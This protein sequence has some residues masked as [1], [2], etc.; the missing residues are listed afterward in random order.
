MANRTPEI[1]EIPPEFAHDLHNLEYLETADIVLFMA[2]NQFMVMDE[3]LAAFRQAYPE[4]SRIFYE[5]L[6]PGLELKQI[7]AGGARLG[8]RE[9]RGTPDVYTA[10]SEAAME[11]LRRRGYIEDYFVYLHNRLVLMVPEGN[12]AGI[13][14]V[15]DLG[16]EEVRISQPGPL[17]DITRYIVA[18]Y[19][20]AGGE[21]LVKK[22]MEEKKAA[23]TTLPT[24]VHHRETPRRIKEGTA[25][26]GPVWATEVENARREGLKVEAV[27]PGKKL[28]QRE[29]VNYF[30]AAL[31][32][33]PHPENAA[34]FLEFIRSRQAQEIYAGYGFVPHFY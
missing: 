3:L 14:A 24:V 20:E 8:N 9:I 27:E 2:G 23:G 17:E 1:P 10:V 32:N 21:V 30:I 26:V 4:V 12:P 18:M 28:D 6:P 25:D 33:A 15:E 16:R 19:R 31:K 13:R 29:K 7:L 22:I 11:E 34:R 5:T